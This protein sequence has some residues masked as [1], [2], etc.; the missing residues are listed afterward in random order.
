M[1][2]LAY[3]RTPAGRSPVEDYIEIQDDDGRAKIKAALF[4][5]CEEFPQVE[6]V[7]IKPLKDKLWEIRIPDKRRK[8][9]RLLYVVITKSMV[10]LHAFTKKTQKTPKKELELALRRLR[11][12]LA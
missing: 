1:L 10:I 2:T 8:Q 9:H 6:T 7:S 12:V 3:Y 5:F 4:A 11:D